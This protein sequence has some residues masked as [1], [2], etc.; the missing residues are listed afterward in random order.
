MWPLI[1]GLV[2]L[3][4]VAY[5]LMPKPQS[6]KPQGINDVNVPTSEDGR[7]FPV[8]GGTVFLEASDCAW[9]GDFSA[10]AIKVKSGK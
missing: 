4:A 9:L 8:F 3:V 1:V 10:T 5:A 7:E 6:V 2:A